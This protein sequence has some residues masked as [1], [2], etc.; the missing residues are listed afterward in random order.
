MLLKKLRPSL[1]L[2]LIMV[3]WGV[4]MTAMGFVKSYHGLLIARIFLGIAEAGLFPGVVCYKTVTPQGVS[5]DVTGLLQHNVVLSI[6]STTPPSRL[7]QRRQYRW[8]FLWTPGI[9]HLVY[10]R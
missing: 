6:R 5:N 1:W 7:F 3:A 8:S 4:V 2:P 9:R 10:G